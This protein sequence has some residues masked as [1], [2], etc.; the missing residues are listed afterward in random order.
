MYAVEIAYFSSPNF[1]LYETLPMVRSL[2][3][4]TIDLSM[5]SLS[6]A[7]KLELISIAKILAKQLN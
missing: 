3:P 4:L 2:Q 5:H 1:M 7:V 6:F